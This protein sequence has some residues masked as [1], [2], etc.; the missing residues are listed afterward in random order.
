MTH[1]TQEDLQRQQGRVNYCRWI[2][3]Q[4]EA[5]LARLTD[6]EA[7]FKDVIW[8]WGA[9]SGPKLFEAHFWMEREIEEARG[10][11]KSE[12][13]RLQQMQRRLANR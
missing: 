2:V 13:H 10:W 8:K 12:E 1:E 6:L 11:L 3:T 7:S 4:R 9:H 5:A